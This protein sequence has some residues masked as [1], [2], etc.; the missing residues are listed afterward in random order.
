V[1][2]IRTAPDFLRF[3]GLPF[4]PLPLLRVPIEG[5]STRYTVASGQLA[6]AK[7]II[8]TGPKVDSVQAPAIC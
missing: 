1:D 2:P 8:V 6:E 7:E 5:V 4:L 3:S